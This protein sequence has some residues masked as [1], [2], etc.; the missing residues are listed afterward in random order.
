[1][2]RIRF[3]Q[4]LVTI[5]V[6]VCAAFTAIPALAAGA[7]FTVN[8]TADNPPSLFSCQGAPGD[9]SLRQAIVKANGFEGPHT[10]VLPAGHYALTLKGS[11]ENLGATGD[12]DV[13]AN[14][15]IT[16]EGGGARSTVVDATGLED[17]VFEVQPTASL[18]LSR[19]TVTGGLAIDQSGGGIQAIEA[20]LALDRVAV[21]GNVSSESGAGG[22]L[23]LNGAK[24]TISGSLI[25]E[26]RNSGDGGGIFASDSDLFIVN[27]SIVNNV[28]DT[29]L[30]PG[31]TGWGAYGGGMEADGGNLVLQNVTIAGNSVAD[32]NGGDEGGGAGIYS[33]PVT[34][35]IVNTIVYG[36]TWFNVAPEERSQCSNTLPSEGHNIEEQPLP[37]QE[38]CF[39]SPTD[40]ITN[41]LLGALANNGGETDTMAL[42]AGSPAIDAGLLARCPAVDQRGLPRPQFNGCDIGAFEVQPVPPPP[43]AVLKPTIKRGKVKVKKAGKT[44][45]VW[46]GFLVSCPA[47]AQACT[48]TVKARAAKVKPKG[49]AGASAK[50]KV[51]VGKAKFKVAPG[52]TK[53][54]KLKLNSRG[55]KMLR[56]L[57]KLRTQF[58]VVT[59]VGSGP[60]V[61]AKRTAKLKLPKGA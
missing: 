22:G 51:L 37:G 52:K 26:N 7:T 20:D 29:S 43:P 19:L 3:L 2:S 31:N 28:V 59:R 50:K 49:K 46:P 54:L 17:R 32:K 58:E 1:M 12:L 61:K 18:S 8:T 55:A 14:T 57:G 15:Q 53:A 25:A 33:T 4:R 21:R 11:E 45:Q 38:R 27:T 35:Q 56:E 16:I 42:L 36:N 47:G 40:A 39:G 23:T 48:G 30:Y 34:A 9:C 60:Q 6:A 13:T 10:I 41:P 24:A 5:A 44:F